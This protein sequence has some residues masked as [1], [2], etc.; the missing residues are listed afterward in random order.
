MFSDSVFYENILT[1]LGLYQHLPHNLL[2]SPRAHKQAFNLRK[3]RNR[4]VQDKSSNLHC[5]QF[6][7]KTSHRHC[8]IKRRISLPTPTHFQSYCKPPDLCMYVSTYE[9]LLLISLVSKSTIFDSTNNSNWFYP[10]SLNSHALQ[11][12]IF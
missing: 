10:N 12:I 7:P 4:T 1:I 6:Y 3:H 8:W 5:P 2:L 11:Q 9:K